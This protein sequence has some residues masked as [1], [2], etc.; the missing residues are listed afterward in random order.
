MPST[1]VNFRHPEDSKLVFHLELFDHHCFGSSCE[2]AGNQLLSAVESWAQAVQGFVPEVPRG[3]SQNVT[4]SENEVKQW[5]ASDRANLSPDDA[6]YTV[7]SSLHEMPNSGMAPDRLNVARAALS[8]ALNATARWAP[9]IVNPVDIN[10]MGMVY[11]F[12]ILS[13]W[14]YN[15]GVR[16]LI[17]GNQSNLISHRFNLSDNVIEDPDF[18]T[19]AWER[20]QQGSIEAADQNGTA[21]NNQGFKDDYVELS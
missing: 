21:A 20:V 16:S 18:A 4:V 2:D 17:F 10:G 1:R 15:K 6:P 13:Y 3:V 12:D 14:G 8:K 11:R 19:M 7:Y 9:Q 5:I